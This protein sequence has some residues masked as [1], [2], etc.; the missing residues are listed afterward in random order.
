MVSIIEA[1]VVSL[2]ESVGKVPKH[3]RNGCGTGQR[4]NRVAD[5]CPSLSHI[6]ATP[7][8]GA[9]MGRGTPKRSDTERAIVQTAGEIFQDGPV[10]EVLS[11]DAGSKPSLLLWKDGQ[12]PKVAAEI[13]RDGTINQPPIVDRSIWASTTLPTGI[14]DRG[15]SA[16]LFR[17]TCQLFETH[18]GIS[19][20]EPALAT[21]WNATT[22]FAD[23]LPNPVSLF[24]HGTD[25]NRAM[26]FLWVLRCV[27]RHALILTELSRQA[28]HSLMAVRP[29]L[30]L[31]QPQN[32]FSISHD[33]LRILYRGLVVPRFDGGVVD[34]VSSKAIFVGRPGNGPFRISAEIMSAP[35]MCSSLALGR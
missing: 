27:A 8:W 34:L 15:P 12:D 30:L 35:H 4:C 24:I 31:D 6:P 13:E 10:L 21:S 9:L 23:I 18:V 5:S 7:H 16:N 26:R 32:V 1:S 28:F 11:T 29:T 19:A 33:V 17:E 2:S 14:V 22:W 20:N 25:M 3:S